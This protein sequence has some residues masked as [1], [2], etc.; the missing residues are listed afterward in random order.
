MRIPPFL[1]R[2]RWWLLAPA[3]LLLLLVLAIAIVLPII[4]PQLTPYLEGPKFRA[5][6][7]KQTSKGLH[8]DGQYG[9]IKRTGFDTA[10]VQKFNAANGVKA[11]KSLEARDVTAKFNPWGIFLRR[12]QL[13]YIHIKRGQVEIQTYEPKPDPKKSKPWYSIFLPDRVYLRE[14]TC[15]N[16]DVTWKMSGKSGGIFGTKVLITPYGRDFEY[17]AEGGTMRTGGFTPDLAM[18]RLHMV[19]TK[20]VLDLYELELGPSENSKGFIRIKG[21]MGMREDKHVDMQLDF[22]GVPVAPWLPKD[23]DGDIKGSAQGHV[24]WKG[25][26]Q[27]IE[28]S[29]GEGELRVT[30]GELIELPLLEFLAA[31]TAR[32]S[33]KAITLTDCEVK[34][35]WKYPRFEIYQLDLVGEEKVSIRGSI[36]VNK[37]ALSGEIDLGLAPTYLDWLPKAKEEIFTREQ[38][39]MVWTKVK[40]SG[41]LKEPVDDLTPRLAATLKKDPAAATGLFLRGVGEWLEQKI[42]GRKI[43][44]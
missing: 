11:M 32:K 41:T 8:F 12:W 14:V 42:K 44:P 31:A 4:S 35:R 33:L 20:K 16:A 23:I 22:G 27:T 3:A 19:I 39:G 18:R 25:T 17:Q 1:K 36:E 24:T 9:P 29:S 28:A 37:S 13:D 21:D 43:A 30:R 15:D 40:L 5:E 34:F 6:L 38:D 10:S 2:Y 7:D 26:D